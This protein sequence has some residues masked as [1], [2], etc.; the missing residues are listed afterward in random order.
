MPNPS[1][2]IP[3]PLPFCD[4]KK[5]T[6]KISALLVAANAALITLLLCVAAFAGTRPEAAPAAPAINVKELAQLSRALKQKNPSPAYVKLSAIAM[7]KSSGT[8]GLRASLALGY[9]DYSKGN[10]A[11]ASKWFARAKGDP[12][13]RDYTLYWD[14]ET[15]RALSHHAEALA[16]LQQLRKDFPDSVITDQALQS[17]AE[18]ALAVNQP[19]DALAALDG[20][21]STGGI[22]TLLFLR[23]EARE[24]AG[25]QLAAAEDYQN[26]Y[27]HFAPS[28]QAP[29]AGMKWDL[30][31]AKL[32][33]QLSPVTLEQRLARAS[34]LYAANRWSEARSEYSALLPQLTGTEH[35][36]AELRILECGAQF[37]AGPDGLAALR[38]TDPEL[39]AER[40]YQLAQVYRT[41]VREADMLGVVEAA[42]ERAPSSSW[43][44]SS[45]FLAGNYYWVLLDRDRASGYYKRLVDNIPSA[46]DA[47]KAQWRVAWTA[48]LQ[49]RPEAA[50]LLTAHIGHYPGSQFTPDAL[51]WLGR[52]AEEAKNPALAWVYYGKLVERY[53]QN[54][55]ETLA[56]ARMKALPN[57]AINA[58]K[59]ASKADL[60]VLATI[61]PVSVAQPLGATIP[62]AAA[63]RQARADALRSIAFDASAEL[64]LRAG[65][66]A[67]GEPRLLLEVAQAANEAGHC[68]LAIVTVRQIYPQ[69][70]SRPFADVPREAWLAAYPMPFAGSI[71]QWSAHAG[72]DPMLVAGLI[73]Q[74]SAFE[75]EARSGANAL[76]LMQLLPK[77]GRRMAKLAKVGYAQGQLYNPDYNVR[78]GTIYFASLKKDF[79]SV[80]SALAAYNAGEERLTE[81]T[82]GQKYRDIPEFVDSIP[83]T[84]TREYVEIVSRNGE[85]YRKLYGAPNELAKARPHRKKH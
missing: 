29:E 21:S 39:D 36:R 59:N 55:F 47:S 82:T 18:A 34:S 16:E 17:L 83:F 40:F 2:N 49:R 6:M 9:F 84:E 71:R 35:E 74:E 60:A 25:Q 58:D 31:H 20:Y 73:R 81:W 22:P 15:N 26:V 46:P 24:Q 85:I 33:D 67:T 28:S 63:N 32:G 13:L 53:P 23:A 41:L 11:L 8:L 37:G 19:N 72:V 43:A 4:T 5:A 66:A 7:L 62:E 14:A 70:E 80:E 1:E 52:L 3:I 54:Y 10:Y 30:L 51:Y 42:A 65:Y 50:D 48:V 45:L 27:L 12:L 69:L 75:P 57:V 68:G 78:L 77:T 76:G 56:A 44:A 38:L 64:E 79:G 61:P